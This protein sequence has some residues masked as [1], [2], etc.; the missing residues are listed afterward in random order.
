MRMSDGGWDAFAL[1]L[2]AT[3]IALLPGSR[4]QE[5]TRMLPI[6][7]DSMELL[8]DSF[9]NLTAVIPVAPNQHVESYI[10]K[11]IQTLSVPTILIPGGSQNLKYDAFSAS[12]AA[13]STSGTAIMELQLARLPCVVAYQA[14]FITEWF[15]KYRTK[16]QYMSLPNIL[17]D[18]HVIPEALFQACTPE[19]LAS[20]VCQLIHDNHLRKAQIVAAE[21][22]F[23]MLIPP[24]RKIS[25]LFQEVGSSFT[26]HSPSMIAA[27][28]ILTFRE[29]E[30]Q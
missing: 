14:H 8:K 25:N 29:K 12:R 30:Q 4:L 21:K 15:I 24:E 26:T 13:L 22:V 7:S 2:G 6:F 11:A 5:V 20:E 23:K 19:Y 9:P 17:L 28:A 1:Y 18:S 27:S 3:I 16:L 10:N